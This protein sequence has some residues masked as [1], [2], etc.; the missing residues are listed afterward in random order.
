MVP[1]IDGIDG[2]LSHEDPDFRERVPFQLETEELSAAGAQPRKRGDEPFHGLLSFQQR[3]RIVMRVREWQILDRFLIILPSPMTLSLKV[4][5]FEPEDLKGQG[6][7]FRDI[8]HLGI[9]LV[10]DDHDVL[11][12]IFSH[13]PR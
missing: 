6:D 11:D 7:E 12:E 10:Q 2:T 13:I 5:H 1:G 9:F 8:R 4:E 3:S